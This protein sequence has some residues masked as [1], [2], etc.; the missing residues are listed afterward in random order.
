MPLAAALVAR[1]LVAVGAVLGDVPLLVADV[2]EVRLTAVLGDVAGLVALV[3]QVLL[4][5]ALPG[6]VSVPA[7]VN[8]SLPNGAAY[9]LHLR[10][11]E[12]P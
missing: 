2:A 7:E 11:L 10:H 9:L 12:V 6:K 8:N 5:P 4:L 3:A 1:L